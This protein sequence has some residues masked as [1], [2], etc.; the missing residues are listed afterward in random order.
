MSARLAAVAALAIAL[1][2][3]PAV[4]P[5]AA[6]VLAGGPNPQRLAQV[7]PSEGQD[8]S[9]REPGGLPGKSMD[10]REPG[11]RVSRGIKPKKRDTPPK[12]DA[13]SDQDKGQSKG[14]S[15]GKGKKK[16]SHP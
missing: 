8:D 11:S 5:A 6:G 16:Q 9:I 3:P 15:K 14:K 7:R 13:K 2:L 1:V 10:A 4:S 12:T